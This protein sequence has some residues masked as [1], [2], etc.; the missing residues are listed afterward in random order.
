[1]EGELRLGNA[2]DSMHMLLTEHNASVLRDRRVH[3]PQRP[4]PHI[5]SE[6]F[7]VLSRGSDSG[8]L[9]KPLA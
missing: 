5:L 8:G 9:I 7:D 1:M 2:G 3:T 4:P 6:S